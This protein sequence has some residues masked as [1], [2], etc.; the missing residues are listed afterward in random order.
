MADVSRELKSSWGENM[1]GS[2]FCEKGLLA[3]VPK[4]FQTYGISRGNVF[5]TV[6]PS[7]HV[8]TG[9][10]RVPLLA[11]PAPRFAGLLIAC[12]SGRLRQG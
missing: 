6:R 8:K 7:V 1:R 9:G 4:N 3:P 10:R 2:P 5:S 12:P 11:C